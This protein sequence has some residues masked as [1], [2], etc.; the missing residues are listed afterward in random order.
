M[1][2]LNRLPIWRR[3]LS[4]WGNT[5][6]VATFDRFLYLIL[7]RL[8]W[9]GRHDRVFLEQRI[10]PGM[11]VVDIGA[12]IGLYTL[13][14]S[15][16]V[17]KCGTVTAIEPDPCNFEL[18]KTNCAFNSVTNVVL[19]HAAAGASHGS[20]R[21]YRSLVHSGDSR[22]VFQ[23]PSRLRQSVEV[24]VRT[25]D[26]LVAGQRVDFIKVDVQGWEGEV[27]KGMK[28]IFARNPGLQISFEY[29]PFG[30]RAAG[31]DPIGLLTTLQELGFRIYPESTQARV[32][33]T[34]FASISACTGDGYTKF[35]NLLAVREP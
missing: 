10:R 25:I 28:E 33:I 24:E 12:N 22:M 15:R 9:M 17:G 32:A 34:D 7:H 13:L 29:W 3:Q 27:F 19:H 30:L 5:L 35:T 2:S 18:L 23:Q 1:C 26:E 14:L 11:R 8:A 20:M 16:L 31:C 4:T 6:T 21:L